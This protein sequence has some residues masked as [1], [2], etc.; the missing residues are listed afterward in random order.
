MR[1]I[2]ALVQVLHGLH[3]QGRKGL[4]SRAGSVSRKNQRKDSKALAWSVDAETWLE[5]VRFANEWRSWNR[6][7]SAL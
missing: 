3:D 1:Q 6:K 4:L 7:E 2:S 5:E